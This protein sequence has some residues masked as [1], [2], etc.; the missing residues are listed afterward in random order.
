MDLFLFF[1]GF[2]IEYI[3][4]FF[5]VLIIVVFFYEL[6]YFVVVCWCNVKVDVFFIGFGKEIVGWNDKC[7][8]CWKILLILF[9]GYVKFVGDENVVSVL[10]WDL[11]VSMSDEDCKIVFIVKLVW[12]CVV[13]VVV[14]FVVNFIFVVVIFVLIYMIYGKFEFLFVVLLVIEGLVVEDVGIVEGDCILLINGKL[15]F[16]FEDL[17]WIVCYNFDQFLVLGIECGGSEIMVIVIL[18]WVDDVN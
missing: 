14:G 18:V 7:G 13:I 1:Y 3:I 8:I 11:I 5:F 4:L 9:G 15:F 12:Q 10:D 6:G 17:K 2:L 16:Y